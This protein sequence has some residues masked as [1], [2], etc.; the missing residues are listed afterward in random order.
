MKLGGLILK[1]LLRLVAA[2]AVLSALAAAGFCLAVL[3]GGP[4]A[5]QPLGRVWF[6]NDPFLSLT[7]SPSIQLVQVF[8]ERKLALPALWDPGAVTVLNWPAAIALAAIAA[9]FSVLALCAF[10]LARLG[11]PYRQGDRHVL[12]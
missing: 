6:Q 7:G 2:L 12:Q 3:A 9:G 1:G 8:F 5:G 10:G 11:R 4:L